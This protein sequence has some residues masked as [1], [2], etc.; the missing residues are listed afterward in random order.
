MLVLVLV[1]SVWCWCWCLTEQTQQQYQMPNPKSQ[2]T[3]Q[4]GENPAQ[5]L[6][7]HVMRPSSPGSQI[8]PLWDRQA[9]LGMDRPASGWIGTPRDG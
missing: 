9:R 8:G 2:V 5:A 4:T 6:L 3:D 7:S 1:F